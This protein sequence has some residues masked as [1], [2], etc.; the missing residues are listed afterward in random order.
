[1]SKMTPRDNFEALINGKEPESV[2]VWT[3]G[4]P[5]RNGETTFQIISPGLFKNIRMPDVPNDEKIDEWGVKYVANAET[6]Y[7]TLPE[8]GKFLLKDITK[9]HDVIKKPETPVFDWE[10][11]AKKDYE[12]AKH[13]PRQ[14]LSCAMFGLMPFQQ[15]MAFMGFDEGL[16]AMYEEP[17][18]VKELLNYLV[19][20][21]EPLIQKTIDYYKPDMMY[22]LDDTATKTNPFFSVEMYKDILKPVY[23]R[24]TK[25][26]QDRGI[27]I[28]FHNCGRCEDFI[29]DMIDFGIKIWDPA[30]P[31]NDLVGIKK[32]YNNK[33]PFCGSYELKIPSTWPEISEEEVRQSVR[34][35]IDKYAPGGGY[36]FGGGVLTAAGDEVG[37]KVNGWIMDEAYNY[38]QDYYSKH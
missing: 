10:S 32:K 1:M 21:Y 12:T 30:Q 3:M 34:D 22:L 6:G 38:G 17:E 20:F 14:A 28:E 23:Q 33:F 35:T 7:G 29:D 9:W 31:D 13:D 19:D 36:A 5:G 2:V 24:M 25:P 26:A 16:C 15:L 18:L 11:M 27:P 8:P 37:M 4:M